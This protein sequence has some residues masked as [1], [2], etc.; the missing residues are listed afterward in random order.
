VGR[1]RCL[2]IAI[3]LV[4]PLALV[5][6]VPAQVP[7]P[8][9]VVRGDWPDPDVTLIGGTYYAVATSGNWAPTFR[10]LTS[11][12]LRTWSMAGSVFRR[13]P[14]WAKDSFWAPELTQLPNGRF[15]VFYSAYPRK[16]PGRPWYCLGVATAPSPLGPWRDLGRPL[17]CGRHGAIDA[18]PVVDGDDLHLAYKEDGNA[19]DRPTRILLQRLRADGLELIGGPREL[20]RNRP[21]SWERLVVEA[22]ALVQRDGWWHMLYSGNL[23]C[24]RNCAYAVGA[25]RARTLAGPWRRHPGNP[26]LRSG[27]GWRCP[28]HASIVGDRVA[29]HAYRSGAGILAGRQLHLAP[30][31]FG[32]DGWPSIGDGS[33]L[34]PAD[35]AAPTSFDDAFPG[36]TL[37]PEWEWPIARAPRTSVADGLRLTAPRSAGERL[38]AGVLS[39]RLGSHRF[40]ATAVVDRG[41]RQVTGAAGLAV[42]RGGPFEVGRQAV[43]IAVDRSFVWGWRRGRGSYTYV[44]ARVRTPGPLVHLRATADGRR[45]RF[46]FSADGVHWNRAGGFGRS[47]VEETARIALT[48]GGSRGAS[49]RFARAT[50][51]ER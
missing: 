11:P 49:V 21:R 26:I 1:V 33:P 47:P 41:A 22:P 27:N 23:C 13:P 39:R 46:H 5:P 43:G 36:G 14:R 12:D 20:L 8:S 44:G 38:D 4:L 40:T 19:F 2:P 3:A 24:S 37:A 42:T 50:L 9:P 30:L 35:G 25:A 17:R 51:V 7:Q 10:I 18:T 15:A 6:A 16:R 31:A 45:V 28:G 29:F 34:P 48:A 32:A